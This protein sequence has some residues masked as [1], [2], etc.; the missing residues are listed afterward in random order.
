M[1]GYIDRSSEMYVVCLDNGNAKRS[2]TVL[3]FTAVYCT[4]K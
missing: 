4:Y 2:C 3:N 1:D